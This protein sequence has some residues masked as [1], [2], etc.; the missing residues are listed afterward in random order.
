[1]QFELNERI[2]GKDK[3]EYTVS[4]MIALMNDTDRKA[5]AMKNQKWYQKMLKTV[6][7]KN[8]AAKEEIIEN[9]EKLNAY[10]A[11]TIAELYR[12][13]AFDTQ[14][15]VTLGAQIN[16]VYSNIPEI[17]E[18]L[19]TTAV[20]LNSKIESLDSFVV[21]IGNIDTGKYNN[22]N[23]IT[24]V[25]EIVS[26]LDER[27]LNNDEKME[28][29]RS[30][31]RQKGCIPD[32]EK[33]LDELAGELLSLSESDANE[34][35]SDLISV[36]AESFWVSVFSQLIEQ[37]HFLAPSAKKAVK[38][39]VIV[40][41]VLVA[42]NLEPGTCFSYMEIFD[43]LVTAKQEMYDQCDHY[44][45]AVSTTKDK[46][47]PMNKTI[48]EP[49]PMEKMAS[50]E[51]SQEEEY[52]MP[53]AGT[54]EAEETINLTDE[55]ISSILQIEPEQ[56]REFKNKRL[57]FK[58]FI[59]CAGTLMFKNCV[60][61]YNEYDGDEITINSGASLMMN[62]CVVICKGYDKKPFISSLGSKEIIIEKC[63]FI[64]C[65]NFIYGEY[66]ESFSMQYCY[67]RDCMEGF[68]NLYGF[69]SSAIQGNVFIFNQLNKYS[70][71]RDVVF[72]N[73]SSNKSATFFEYNSAFEATEF[74]LN[75]DEPKKKMVGYAFSVL[76]DDGAYIKNCSFVNLSG[77][78][79]GRAFTDCWFENCH[80]AITSPS[81][82]TGLNL[83]IDK[84]IFWGS[85]DVIK[86][87]CPTSIKNCKFI[88]CYGQLIEGQLP[89]GVDIEFCEFEFIVNKD[90]GKNIPDFDDKYGYNSVIRLVRGDR[91]EGITNHINKCTFNNI[92]MQQNYL[93]SASNVYYHDGPIITIN[94]CRF[95]N[96]ATK[97][98]DKKLI[99]EW[100]TYDRFL[101]RNIKQNTITIYSC[102]GLDNINSTID[103]STTEI[104]I[105]NQDQ[106]IG[107]TITL[108]NWKSL[109]KE[110]IGSTID[111]Q[112]I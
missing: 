11:E 53:S 55:C 19:Y 25:C 73:T 2:P 95:S 32:T 41:R 91:K 34:M 1:M 30:K 47:L 31:I 59:N 13:E 54:D 22:L 102:T 101:S 36:G 68:I 14:T 109:L 80:E 78:I 6:L 92:Q 29:L 86:A 96:C 87:M 9:H 10:M 105:P 88:S 74:R 49:E 98:Q 40:D 3:I 108:E 81:K 64:D 20:S 16:Q 15:L 27:I 65:I 57:H 111:Y 79:E 38:A 28:I 18:I 99:K 24:V 45:K 62:N 104:N 72:I 12:R 61:F 106:E 52:E 37:Y 77:G 66:I 84:C 85:T 112:S 75:W 26:K 46:T 4:Q 39:N 7:G 82:F 94:D 51:K 35:Y 97:R 83:E 107:S 71:E 44:T 48:S 43:D 69:E 89:G 103:T 8:K 17:K 60:I 76:K 58:S 67:T 23:S 70:K 5:D 100:D 63:T 110:L 90:N 93:I 56:T 21:L 33:T 50:E 42:N